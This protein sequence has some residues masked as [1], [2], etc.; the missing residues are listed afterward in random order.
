MDELTSSAPI[1]IGSGV[2]A[3]FALA[4][5]RWPRKPPVVPQVTEPVRHEA[6]IEDAV[7]YLTQETH[8]CDPGSYDLGSRSRADRARALIAE[9]ARS[10]KLAVHVVADDGTD[11]GLL[12]PDPAGEALRG[13]DPAA[14]PPPPEIR[15]LFGDDAIKPMN[16]RVDG[17]QMKLL[18]PS[19][20]S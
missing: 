8:L 9:A 7:S 12:R 2:L 6:T 17:L 5:L 4:A 10:G 20:R 1:L 14:L 19:G 3:A 11:L 18:W 16:L 13:G 15:H